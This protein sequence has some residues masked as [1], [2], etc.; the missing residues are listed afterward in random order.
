MN[1]LLRPC[2][3][4]EVMQRGMQGSVRETGCTKVK[5]E[6]HGDA[7]DNISSTVFM[8]CVTS[9]AAAAASAAGH[10]RSPARPRPPPLTKLASIWRTEVT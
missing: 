4:P 7:S 6:T 1:V 10:V 5:A 2:N 3:V 9:S 8:A